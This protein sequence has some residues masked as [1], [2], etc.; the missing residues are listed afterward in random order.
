MKINIVVILGYLIVYLVFTVAFW[1]IFEKAGEKKWKAF[2]PIYNVYVLISLV[3]A[4][5][6]F[7]IIF[8]LFAVALTCWIYT[9]NP[10]VLASISTGQA[11]SLVTIASILLP[12]S[13]IAL[14]VFYILLCVRICQ[15]FGLSRGWMLVLAVLFPAIFLIIG[16][17][18]PQYQGNAY[19]G[20]VHIKDTAV[21]NEKSSK[22]LE[23]KNI[24]T[25]KKSTEVKKDTTGKNS[26]DDKKSTS[27]N[28]S[29]TDKKSTEVKKKTEIEKNIKTEKKKNQNSI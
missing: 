11:Q 8:G 28:K 5:K 1:K 22:K 20:Q 26:A 14:M 15:S 13:G 6:F 23:S 12:V 21:K 7:W 10:D 27:D 2:I 4:K 18:W 19:Y 25:G 17:G 3:W 9:Q 29:T 16:L 24:T